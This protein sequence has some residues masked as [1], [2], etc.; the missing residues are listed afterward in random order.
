MGEKL[1]AWKQ[2][3][4]NDGD[5]RKGSD[6]EALGGS[7][8]VSSDARDQKNVNAP[9]VPSDPVPPSPPA[10]PSAAA[11]GDT[12]AT[13]ASSSTP[14]SSS[15]GMES[16]DGSKSS[17]LWALGSAVAGVMIFGAAA[18]AIRRKVQ[19]ISAEGKAVGDA[20][21]SSVEVGAEEA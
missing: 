17:G 9:L 13:S 16:D 19:E 6:D 15:S 14:V 1:F 11:E 2:T 3:H 21:A 5:V 7:G 12:K 20:T 8:S 18:F 10:P 4:T